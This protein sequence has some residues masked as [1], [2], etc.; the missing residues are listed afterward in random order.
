[1]VIFEKS[2]LKRGSE[3]TMQQKVD[4]QVQLV[5]L[6][7]STKSKQRKTRRCFTTAFKGETVKLVKQSE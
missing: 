7:E 4:L 1:M 5:F 2:G 3:F 6:R